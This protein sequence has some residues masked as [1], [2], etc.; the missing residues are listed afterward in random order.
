MQTM[1]YTSTVGLNLNC[2]LDVSDRRNCNA[3][4]RPPSSPGP[5]AA[6]GTAELEYLVSDRV[7]LVPIVGPVGLYCY[8]GSIVLLLA[9][10][11]PGTH[12][13]LLILIFSN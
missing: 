2:E 4:T 5:L 12:V 3:S 13:E 6:A 11:R 1:Q 7:V 9:Y 8:D 10:Y